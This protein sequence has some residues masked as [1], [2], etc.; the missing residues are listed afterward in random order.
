MIAL[1]PIPKPIDTLPLRGAPDAVA[2]EERA[3]TLTYAELE[4][5]VGGIA[6]RLAGRG[7]AAGDRVATWLPKTRAACLL[8]L[9]VPRAGLVHVPIN[10]V[11]KRAQVAHILADS[12]A[13]VLVTQAARIAALEPGD[14]PDG[15][16]IVIE[17][18]LASSDTLP[19]CQADPEALAAILY[20]S[21]STGRPKGVMLSHANLWFGAISVAQYLEIVS[22]DRV[23]G[24]LPLSFDYGQ[25]QLLS[26]WA[27]GGQVTPLDYLTA[28]DVVKA[29]ER[30]DVTTLAGVPPLWVQLLEAEWP[31]ETAAR[32]KRLT[33]SG[34][35]LTPRLVRGLRALFPNADLYPMYGLTEAFRSTY[36]APALVDAHPESIGRAIPF[37]EIVVVRPDGTRAAAGEPG[38]LVHAGP[39][40]AHGYWQDAER[41]AQRFRPAP[42]FATSG[43][44][45][46]WSGDTVIQ[47]GEGLLRFVGR[48]DEMIK[49]AGNRISPTEIEDA[50][51]SGGEVAEA[52]AFGV[53]D[54]RLGQ[55]IVVV[56]RGDGAQEDAL[57]ARLRRELPSFMQPA[58]YDWRGALPRNANGKLDRTA[59]RADLRDDDKGADA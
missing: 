56:A 55:A 14:V 53:P 44:M 17:E 7:L 38:E 43:G 49:S 50:V 4:T 5:R 13:R 18:E 21:G 25:N 32:L 10:P 37:A 47:D 58:R 2:L 15:C 16:A 51:L 33:N 27:A 29:V 19:P 24:V 3:G 1:D 28:R 9:A 54:A 11:L 39:L 30:H 59:L 45:A 31:S 20:T 46:V 34:G 48:D 57:R 26:T 40:V 23:L 6:H 42:E 22:K 52:A 41:T 12:G 36:L 35:A 8:P